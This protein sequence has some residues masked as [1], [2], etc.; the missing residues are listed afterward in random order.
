M[1]DLPYASGESMPTG[2]DFESRR[3]TRRVIQFGK[4]KIGVVLGDG[5]RFLGIDEL[6]IAKDFRSNEQQAQASGYLD[7]EEFYQD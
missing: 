6:R 3:I 2:A 1:N 5:D 7:V 4:Y